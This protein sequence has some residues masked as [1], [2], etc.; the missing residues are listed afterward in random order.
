MTNILESDVTDIMDS[1]FGPD[2]TSDE[3]SDDTSEDN[4]IEESTDEVPIQTI[5]FTIILVA[6]NFSLIEL[7]D[8][9]FN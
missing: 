5:N 8:L 9:S 6:N 4:A 7:S 3:A 1:I 2:D